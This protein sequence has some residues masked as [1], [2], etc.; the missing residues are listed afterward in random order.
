MTRLVP[1][2]ENEISSATYQAHARSKKRRQL[3]AV[4]FFCLDVPSN[5]FVEEDNYWYSEVALPADLIYS[6]VGDA[7]VDPQDPSR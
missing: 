2:N 4:S 3:V 5:C 6:V 7:M 1:A